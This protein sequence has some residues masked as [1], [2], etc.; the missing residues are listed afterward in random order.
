MVLENF[1][2]NG[3]AKMFQ[4]DASQKVGLQ[5]YLIS[6]T[7]NAIFKAIAKLNSGNIITFSG[8]QKLIPPKNWPISY[9][10]QKL[11]P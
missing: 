5:N 11:I 4:N 9:P 3:F 2:K 8:L 6:F 7:K 10:P 1:T